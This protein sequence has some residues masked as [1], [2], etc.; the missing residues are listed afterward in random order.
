MVEARQ[1]LDDAIGALSD[2]YEYG[3]LLAQTEPDK[4]LML[5]VEEIR[6]A[7]DEKRNE[8]KGTRTHGR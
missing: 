8:K 5:A 6:K 7:R 1:R 3:H 4:L 2:L